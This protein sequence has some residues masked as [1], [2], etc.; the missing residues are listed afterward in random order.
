[1]MKDNFADKNFS[2]DRNKRCI[3]KTR[4]LLKEL[5]PWF[6]DFVRACEIDKT[7][8]TIL[9]YTYDAKIFFTYLT[10]EQPDFIGMDARDISPALLDKLTLTDFERYIEY[11]GYYFTKDDKEHFNEEKSKARKIASLRTIFKY[12]YKKQLIADNPTELLS[13]PKLHDKVIIRLEPNEVVKLI[14]TVRSGEGL[15]EREKKHH[16]RY[17]KRDIA[18]IVT[19]LTTGMRISEL[20]GLNVDDVDFDNMSLRITRK[21]GNQALLYFDFE[22]YDALK[23][24]LDERILKDNYDLPPLFLSSRNN[25][26]SVEAVRV[27]VEKYAKISAPLKKITPHKLRSTYGTMLYQG[28]GDIYLV[29]DVLG[30]KDVNTTRKHYA[31]IVEENRKNAASVVKLMDNEDEKTDR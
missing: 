22:T 2:E 16:A 31:A 3:L 11:L 25:R 5:P 28:T 23:D 29:A 8:L 30:H 17:V 12:L 19:F 15:T 13:T 14:N 4:E 9:N 24:Y 20:V 21:G 18:I 1:M 27:M 10:S 6:S 7:R 26:M